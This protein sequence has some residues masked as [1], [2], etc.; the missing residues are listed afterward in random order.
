M[1]TKAKSTMPEIARN[2][3]SP[4]KSLILPPTPVIDSQIVTVKGDSIPG[5]SFFAWINH[6]IYLALKLA[7]TVVARETS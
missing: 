6:I 3:V 2:P 7:E 4:D 5:T 1:I